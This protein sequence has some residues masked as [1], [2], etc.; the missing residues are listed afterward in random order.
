MT[1]SPKHERRR[2]RKVAK[3]WYRTLGL[4]EW[5]LTT[6]YTDGSLIVADVLEPETVAFT[7]ARWQYRTATIE[8]NLKQTAE[9]ND[10]DLEEVYLHEAMHILLNEM[11]EFEPGKCEPEERTAST[12]SFVLMRLRKR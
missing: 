5:R 8:F 6:K 1:Y 2:I 11:R 3:K 12:L 9:L 4:D 10:S 7:V